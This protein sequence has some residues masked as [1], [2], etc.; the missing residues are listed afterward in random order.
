MVGHLCREEKR[1]LKVLACDFGLF[2]RQDVKEIIQTCKSYS[3]GQR[4]IL[5][6]YNRVYLRR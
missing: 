6:V 5:E 3:D 2:E 4:K 1:E